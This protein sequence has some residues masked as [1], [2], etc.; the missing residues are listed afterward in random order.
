MLF[1]ILLTLWNVVIATYIEQHLPVAGK[2]DQWQFAYKQDMG[3]I[4]I[5]LLLNLCIQEAAE[6]SILFVLQGLIYPQSLTICA[7]ER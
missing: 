3:P 1:T 5:I 4:D 7:T 6:W 2:R